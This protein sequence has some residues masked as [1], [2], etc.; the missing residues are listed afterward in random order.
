MNDILSY[1]PKHL[2]PRDQQVNILKRVED[3]YHK[4]NVIIIKAPVAVGKTAVAMTIAKWAK[5][6]ATILVPTNILL[7]QI[8]NE[9]EDLPLLFKK[10]WYGSPTQYK[11]I[12]ALV[13]QAD[14]RAMNYHVYKAN[15]MYSPLCIMDEAHKL[16]DILDGMYSVKLWQNKYPFPD[17]I[18]EVREVV[19]W[20]QYYQETHNDLALDRALLQI[21]NIQDEAVVS[22]QNSYLRG[23]PQKVMHITPGTPR[24]NPP[25]LWPYKHVK[26]LILMSATTG[27]KDVHELG[28]DGRRVSYIEVDSPIPAANRRVLFDPIY[29]MSYRYLDKAVD[30][31]VE[32]ISKLLVK[33]RDQKGLIHAPYSVSQ[34]IQERINDPRIIFHTRENKAQ[35]LADFRA[36]EGN[37]VL[38]VSGLYEGVDL[39]Y[40]AARWQVISKVPFLYLGDERIKKHAEVDPQWYAWEAIKKVLQATGRIVRAPDDFGT[41]YIYDSNFKRLWTEDQ[42]LPDHLRMF[43]SY[44]LDSLIFV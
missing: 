37:Q 33:Y 4:S 29:N 39:P 1:F 43:P 42:K 14:Y 31:L 18:K 15:K 25:Y 7:E 23:K 22:Y 41:T 44:F 9:Y 19:E 34:K 32:Q 12:K 38:V 24:F 17:H 36:N 6:Q 40:D 5:E 27:N 26:K 11:E 16:L 10:D 30:I 21:I 28:L 20:I 2:T 13:K 3:V 8:G 35:V